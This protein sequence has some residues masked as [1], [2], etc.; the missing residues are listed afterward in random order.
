MNLYANI[1]DCDN[2]GVEAGVLY[3]MTT[4]KSLC[5][6]CWHKLYNVQIVPI[7]SLPDASQTHTCE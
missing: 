5:P 2:C 3:I 7:D 1:P 4:Q 6:P